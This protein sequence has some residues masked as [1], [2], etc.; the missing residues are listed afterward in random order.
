MRADTKTAL[1]ELAKPTP[2][3]KPWEWLADNL[4]YGRVPNYDT[5][6]KSAYDPDYFPGWKELL[7]MSVDLSTREMWVLK[8]SRAGGTENLLLGRHRYGLAAHPCSTLFIT[9][10]ERSAAGLMRRRVKRG[11]GLSKDT[12]AKYARAHVLE[13]DIAFDGMD[14]RVGWVNDK[15]I[16]KQ[17][18]YE[19]ILGDEMSLWPGQAA[20]LLR[21]RTAGYS[22]STILAVSSMDPKAKRPTSQ[23]PIWIEYHNGNQLNWY[24]PDPKT[25]RL[26][27]FEKG[28]ASHDTAG[29]KWSQE[30]KREDGTWDLDIVRR[31]AYY[32]TPDGTK[33]TD[34]N[35]MKIARRGKWRA[36]NPDAPVGIITAKY[37]SPMVPLKS[38][39]F[40]E[41]AVGFLKA[42]AQVNPEHM[43]TYLY[44][45]WCEEHTENMLRVTDSLVHNLIQRNHCK[46]ELYFTDN[47]DVRHLYEKVQRA[48]FVG[49]DV[50]QA[51]LVAY[52]EEYAFPGDHATIGWRHCQTWDEVEAFAN[53]VRASA[54]VVDYGYPKRRLEVLQECYNR[55]A[56]WYPARGFDR[57][58][59]I[60]PYKKT[61]LDPFEGSSR[62]TSETSVT[63]YSWQNDIFKM[64]ALELLKGESDKRWIMYEHPEA[65]LVNELASEERVD[66]VWKVKGGHQNHLWDCKLLCLLIAIISGIYQTGYSLAGGQ[67]EEGAAGV[68]E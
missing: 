3:Q 25:R 36:E 43:R 55:G 42:K 39:S 30:A 20:D 29:L 65:Q 27:K 26:F 66:G 52:A 44:E 49:V 2:P 56:G 11:Y 68:T 51:H 35:R 45:E 57:D 62:Q 17:D 9:G 23:D 22:F 28:D 6:N 58:S 59:L 40:G 8:C 16:Y 7:E 31:T 10:S 46:G 60:L 32:Q 24:M 63:T 54:V 14:F 13:F 33:I 18:G 12:A 38:G 64:I 34:K 1:I 47:E 15:T 48:T 53:Q 61:P 4:D 37:V 5:E 41:L 67:E 21:K 19:L 50:Q